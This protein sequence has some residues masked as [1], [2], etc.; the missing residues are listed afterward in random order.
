MQKKDLSETGPERDKVP[1]DVRMRSEIPN[2]EHDPTEGED[3]AFDLSGFLQQI[4]YPATKEDLI[5]YATDQGVE[6]VIFDML[7]QLPDTTYNSPTDV[8]QALEEN[9]N[10]V[11]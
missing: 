10:V 8:S 9:S 4:N 7:E 5:D 2:V 1:P 3:T 6:D 11:K